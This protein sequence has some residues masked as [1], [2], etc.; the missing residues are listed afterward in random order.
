MKRFIFIFLISIIFS[1]GFGQTFNY[2]PTSTTNQIIEHTYFILS[3][4][5]R[6]EQA[7]WVAYELTKSRVY[8]EVSRTDN[9]REDPLVKTGSAT[10]NDYK[11]SGYDRGHLAPAGDMKFSKTAMS[12]S[13]YMSNMSPQIPG[14]NRG[15]WKK[16]EGQ[17]RIWAVENEHIYIVTGGILSSKIGSIGNSVTIPKYY[18]KVILDYKEPGIKAIALILPN[19]KG[20][21]QLDEYVVT[22]DRVENLTGIDFFPA[23]PDDLENKLEAD[24]D[25]SK[26]SFKPITISSSSKSQSVRCKGITQAGARCKR[27]TT[28]ENGYCWQH[29]DQVNGTKTVKPTPTK[30]TVAVQC[31]GITQSGNRCKRK[32]TNLNGYCWQHQDQVKMK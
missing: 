6:N 25:P 23:L 9:F 30:R 21:K 31:K 12:E 13:F 29:Q 11:G 18:Y 16:L 7:E 1:N 8:G 17:V 4:S 22:I 32:T 27:M 19:E 28:S 20:T 3:Y 14:F 10:L 26:W 15:I 24:S 5:E 2:L